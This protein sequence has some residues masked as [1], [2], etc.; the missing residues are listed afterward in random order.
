MGGAEQ[1]IPKF[2]D[3]KTVQN[4]KLNIVYLLNFPFKI[5]SQSGLELIMLT[6]FIEH[7][8]TDKSRGVYTHDDN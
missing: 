6:K 4:V 7:K 1:G 8:T 5:L 3:I 2:T